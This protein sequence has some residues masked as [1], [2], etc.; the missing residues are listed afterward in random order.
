MSERFYVNLPLSRR[1]VQRWM[2]RKLTILPRYAD[3][4]PAT[5]FAYSTATAMNTRLASCRS[6]GARL[7]W[8]SSAS[9]EPQRELPFS[10]EVAAAMPKGDRGQFLIEKLT[11]LGVTAFV[12]LLCQRS[13][14]HPREAKRDKLERHVIEASKQCGR[15]VLMKIN[16][17]TDWET[18][19]TRG[20]A[21][22]VRILGHPHDAS[23]FADLPRH[24]GPVRLAV[25]PE[26]GFTDEE[27]A[28]AHQ[29]DW[30]AVN[31][32][33]RILRIETAAIALA[34]LA[35]PADRVGSV[36]FGK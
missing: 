29:H 1:A 21:G 12:P 34:I 19:A 31:L 2:A 36:T 35:V 4:A 30:R 27:L 7:P 14:T 8:K 33:P 28:L 17:V 11:E 25:G 3:S 5:P 32:G 26:G 22:E 13:N 16:E 24:S 15:N 20:D 10:L 6:G 18:Y 9:S 23:Q